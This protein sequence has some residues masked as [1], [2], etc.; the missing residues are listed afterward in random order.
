V[1]IEQL[2]AAGVAV[3]P[4]SVCAII[5]DQVAGEKTLGCLANS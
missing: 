3:V 4:E 2:G 5:R 1:L